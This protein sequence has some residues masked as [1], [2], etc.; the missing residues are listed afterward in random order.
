ML[1][2]YTRVHTTVAGRWR[3]SAL[4]KGP[5]VRRARRRC[6]PQGALDTPYAPSLGGG[7][8]RP[9]ASG[10]RFAVRAV[11]GWRRA[12]ALHKGPWVRRTR[13]RWAAASVS[14]P[15][16]AL[17][18]PYAPPLGGG[19]VGPPQV[20]CNGSHVLL[21][22]VSVLVRFPLCRFFQWHPR[23]AELFFCNCGKDWRDSAMEFQPS[24][25]C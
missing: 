15:Q 1:F 5:W 22:F 6:P 23:L 8:R 4:H 10:L 24:T 21:C 9:T 7:E 25:C 20:A 13:R 16:G 17:G 18:W 14:P 12:S 19:S 3:A 2:F 11:D